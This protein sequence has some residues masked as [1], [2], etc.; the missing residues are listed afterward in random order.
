MIN[1]FYK[2]RIKFLAGLISEEEIV[3]TSNSGRSDEDT[4]GWYS[5]DYLLVLGSDILTYLDDNIK[6]EEGL[7]LNL[8]KSSTKLDGNS[9]FINIKVNGDINE[10]ELSEEFDLTL[11]VK[12]SENSNTVASISYRGTNNK[13]NLSSKHSSKDLETFKSNIVNN[14]MNSIKLSSLN[15][16]K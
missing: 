8:L 1:E 13:F 7:I 5:E 11:T 9:L 2:N 3:L 4:L 14:V 6:N 16:K 12:F 10:K 15:P